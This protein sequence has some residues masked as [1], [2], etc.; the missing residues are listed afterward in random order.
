MANLTQNLTQNITSIPTP[1]TEVSQTVFTYMA[2][3]PQQVMQGNAVAIMISLIFLFIAILLISAIS[4]FLLSFLKKTLVFFIVLLVIYDFVPRYVELVKNSGWTFSNIVIGIIAVI[5]IALGFF[6]AL[7]SFLKSAKQHIIR[8]SDRLQHRE[9]NVLERKKLELQQEEDLIQ[10]QKVKGIFTK[11]AISHE[12]PITAILIYL[13]V[14]EFGVFSSPTLS[15]PNVQVGIM[16]FIIFLVGIL[17]FTKSSYK[18]FKTAMTYFG[19]TFAV[20]LCLSF[21]LGML[22]GTNTLAE[23]FSP[24]FFTSDSLVAMITGMGVSLFAGSKG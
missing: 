17:I 10:K 15:A 19:V 8:V 6:I 1:V 18:D 4:S 22:W 13:V 9:M 12:K 14:A 11:D 24:L 5:A 16:F 20:G 7:R 3:L 2:S 21:L 23:L